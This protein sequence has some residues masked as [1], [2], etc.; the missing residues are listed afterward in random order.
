M[1]SIG[2]LLKMKAVQITC[3]ALLIVTTLSL[4]V[5][6]VSI[7][8]GGT[9]A[10]DTKRIQDVY[11]LET[12]SP[13]AHK[14]LLK[15][16]GWNTYKNCLIERKIC[17]KLGKRDF[18]QGGCCMPPPYCGYEEKNQTWVVPKTGQ[19]ADDVNCVRWDS[20]KRKLCYDCETCQA[21]Y[22]ST[23]NDSWALRALGPILRALILAACFYFTCEDDWPG[24]NRSGGRAD[25]NPSGGRA[26]N[27]RSGGR[28]NNNRSGRRADNDL[29]V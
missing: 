21:V 14:F 8:I 12:Y 19:Y 1:G 26:H 28:A 17:D 15:D 24:T 9:F 5:I 25:N 18:V 16:S 4:M 10:E 2:V 29:S 11:R 23:F 20:D 6:N 27:N 3:M 22:I 7:D 13:W